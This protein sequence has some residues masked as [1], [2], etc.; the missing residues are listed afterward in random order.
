MKTRL[1]APLLATVLVACA[2]APDDEPSAITEDDP[3]AD[4]IQVAELRE[5]DAV[6]SFE[7][8]QHRVISEDYIIL[9]DRRRSHLATFRRPCRE[10]YDVDVTPDI[11]FDGNT[12]RARFDTIRG[13]RI[14]ALYEISAGQA[15]EIMQ[16][17]D[18]SGK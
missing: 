7:S 18:A 14:E 5:V 2:T 9:Y 8:L 16:L 17:G 3:I 1:F 10:L 6:R 12:V 11:R 4:Y 15:E 13:C